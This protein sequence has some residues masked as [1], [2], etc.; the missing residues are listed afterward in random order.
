[1]KTAIHSLALLSTEASKSCSHSRPRLKNIKVLE[2]E[3]VF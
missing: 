3:I 1:M 2:T